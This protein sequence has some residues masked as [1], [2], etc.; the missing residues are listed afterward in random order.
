MWLLL[1]ALALAGDIDAFP[2]RADVTLPSTGVSRIAVPVALRS[3]GDPADG[4]D[5]ML[6]N[7]AGDRVP[8]A[9]RR[10]NDAPRLIAGHRG[11][12]FGSDDLAWSPTGDAAT[13]RVEVT[14]RPVDGLEITL[15]HQPLAATATVRQDGRIVAERLIYN[16]ASGSNTV[17][18]LPP[19]VGT[20]EL[21]LTYH[22]AGATRPQRVD[23]L[24]YPGPYLPD[25]RVDVPVEGWRTLEDGWARYDILLPEP[26]PV[27]QLDLH[28]TEVL[29]ERSWSLIAP[30]SADGLVDRP[31]G[32]E[33]PIRRLAVG[34]ASIDQT[35]V[36]VPGDVQRRLALFIDGDDGRYLTIPSVTATFPAEELVVRDPGAGPFT[37]YAGAPAGTT[38]PSDLQFALP[39]L[40]RVA[41]AQVLP[42][43]RQPNP[44][45]V[46][47]E[48]RSGAG[49]PGSELQRSDFDWSAPVEGVT[50]LAR[51][52]LT[53][54]VLSTARADLGDL[55]LV[56][57]SNRQIPYLLRHQGLRQ[58]WG[59]LPMT[60]R[61]DGSVS[62][63]EVTLPDR[64]MLVADVTLRTSATHFD[65]SIAVMRPRGKTLQ[66]VRAFQWT[67][68]P[69][70]APL[71]L[72][73]QERFGDKL[74]VRIDNGD[75]P[76]LP[77]GAIEASW[78]RWELVALIPS[79]GAELLYGA[80]R[81][82]RPSYDL[83]LLEQQLR[84][85]VEAE[86]TLGA[87]QVIAP[88]ALPLL[89]RGILGAGVAV[90]GLGLLGLIL[91]MLRHLLPKD[92]PEAAKEEAEIDDPPTPGV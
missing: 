17:V 41:E 91:G 9:V 76:P 61:E 81:L 53:P 58:S 26:Y 92:E 15:P 85:R 23:G 71:N 59:E 79:D 20:F 68:G 75:N 63:I 69:T 19:T 1:S 5:L 18:P 8:F 80:G 39:E 13:F 62:Y 77:I 82:N 51:V 67:G 54:A 55:R 10:G 4:S 70:T 57:S 7:A 6:V 31:Y 86:A 47:P 22:G 32:Y 43:D 38:P 34:G 29:F 35:T 64:N 27:K 90:M 89:D 30:L 78:P 73:L 12:A 84:Q 50:G 36:Q 45:Y 16:V 14:G 52:P 65:R 88:A 49:L 60:R 74:V 72:D 40:V 44:A 11:S 21:T 83:H 33:A 66:T 56:N 2:Y 3:A 28:P 48:Q 37:L 42:G 25:E 87:P 24:R 46:A